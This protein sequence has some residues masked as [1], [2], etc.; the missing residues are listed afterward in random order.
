MSK[1]KYREN[2]QTI[3]QKHDS[4]KSMV[5]GAEKKKNPVTFLIIPLCVVLLIVGGISFFKMKGKSSQ[6][7]AKTD[8]VIHPVKLF[9]DGKARHFQWQTGDGTLIKYFVLKSSDGVIRA[10][11]DACDV[12]WRSGKGYFQEGDNMV[13]RNCGRRFASVKVN[14]VKGGCNP[15]PLMRKV[16]GENLVIQAK[17]ILEGRQYF[18][19]HKRS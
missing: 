11:F 8:E 4:K 12:C 19:F 1:K 7:F 18:D 3:N 2:K 10:A 5:L 14:E 13:C 9:E 15:A 17:D 16:E 6:T